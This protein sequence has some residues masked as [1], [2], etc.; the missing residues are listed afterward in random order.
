MCKT[1]LVLI[2]IP[3]YLEGEKEGGEGGR[4]QEGERRREKG[5]YRGRHTERRMGGQKWERGGRHGK[6]LSYRTHV[7]AP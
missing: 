2:D 5:R 6:T 7:T 4:R 1:I 3:V